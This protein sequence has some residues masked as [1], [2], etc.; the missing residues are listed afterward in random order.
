MAGIKALQGQAR[1][2][3]RK[4][5]SALHQPRFRDALS[6]S[7]CRRLGAAELYGNPQE[8][9]GPGSR[10]GGGGRGRGGALVRPRA[11]PAAPAPAWARLGAAEGREGGRPPRKLSLPSPTAPSPP[12][13]PAPHYWKACVGETQKHPDF[14]AW[15]WGAWRGWG[16]LCSKENQKVR[17]CA[18]CGSSGEGPL[19]LQSQT[20]GWW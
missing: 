12:P 1:A 14:R 9:K 7:L 10:P 2:H 15:G 19:P 4:A 11:L 8:R 17:M 13:R 16:P 20:P 6:L 18:P 3:H 5:S